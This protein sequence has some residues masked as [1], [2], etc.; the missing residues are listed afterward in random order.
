MVSLRIVK[1]LSARTRQISRIRFHCWFSSEHKRQTITIY[2]AS[3]IHSESGRVLLSRIV[4]IKN[5]KV[6]VGK[7]PVSNAN[8]TYNYGMIWW[9]SPF[10]WIGGTWLGYSRDHV[11]TKAVATND[12]Y[13][14]CFRRS[15]ISQVHWSIFWHIHG[16]VN[17]AMF[18]KESWRVVQGAAL[19]TISCFSKQHPHDSCPLLVRSSDYPDRPKNT[20]K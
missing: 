8:S 17:N 9:H 4:T 20:K 6:V 10:V 7:I 19:N 13:G 3:A 14:K 16:T 1:I 15:V 5:I 18:K 2:F 11:I 12:M